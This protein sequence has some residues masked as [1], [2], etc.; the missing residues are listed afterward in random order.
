MSTDRQTPSIVMYAIRYCMYCIQASRLLDAKG[1]E[2]HRID[3]ERNYELRRE[4]ELRTGGRTVP[5]ILVDGQP[6][7]GY[8]ALSALD[9]AGELDRML[10]PDALQEPGRREADPHCA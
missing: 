9:R 5:Q 2:Y 10:F 7:G 8:D 4:M 1:V 3:V 6:I